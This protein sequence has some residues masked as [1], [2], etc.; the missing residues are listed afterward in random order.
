GGAQLPPD[1]VHKIDAAVKTARPGTGYGMTE[2]CGIIT[3]V[4]GDFFVDKPD[5]CGPA[6]PTFEV[7]VVD[8]EGREVPNGQPGELLVRGA[9]VI[10]GY[11]N[12]PEATAASIENGWLKTGD[13]ARIDED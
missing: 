11:L 7:K 10:K 5:S 3:S 12:R 1:L 13:V 2:T 4:G 9:S 8:D 6:C